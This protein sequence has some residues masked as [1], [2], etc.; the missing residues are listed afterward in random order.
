MLVFQI[1]KYEVYKLCSDNYLFINHKIYIYI[2][3]IYNSMMKLLFVKIRE[4]F[5][6]FCVHFKV[7]NMY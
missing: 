3:L 4:K 6:L 7:R 1:I 2:Y 5:Q